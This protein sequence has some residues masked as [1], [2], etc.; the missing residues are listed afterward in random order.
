MLKMSR[1][2][3]STE[4][5]TG[6]DFTPIVKYDARSGR[7]FRIDRI[8]D[9]NGY[10]NDQVDI[11]AIFKAVVDFENVETG[12]RMFLPGVAPSIVV[13]TLA[14][15]EKGGT[16]PDR[17]TP[18]HKNGIRFIMKLTKACGGDKPV[19]EIA[20]MAKVF[21]SGVEEVYEAYLRERGAQGGKLP[22][23]ELAT[24]TPVKSGSGTTSSTN[25]RPVFK[26]TSWVP[27]PADLVNLRPSTAP[28]QPLKPT[29]PA[30]GAQTV[31]PPNVMRTPEPQV[32]MADDDFG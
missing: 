13:T 28:V 7:M 5:S 3:F 17:P 23:I 16:L 29:P 15:L 6:G 24:T 20:G 32:Q 14:A 25:Y 4:P 19:R 27:R 26:I 30:T 2:G 18:E 9:A 10:V 1:F 8:Q 12:W 31:P 21:L 22:V 11:T